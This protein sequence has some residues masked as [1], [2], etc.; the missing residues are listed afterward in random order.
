[1][2]RCEYEIEVEKTGFGSTYAGEF[3]RNKKKVSE[4]PV[5]FDLLVGSLVYRTFLDRTA[6][7]FSDKVKETNA[8]RFLHV[9]ICVDDALF[10][11]NNFEVLC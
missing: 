7:F 11:W 5:T 4:L 9:F 10:L 3:V 1:L 8:V 2:K 6:G